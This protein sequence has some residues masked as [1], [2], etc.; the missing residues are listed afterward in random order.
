MQWIPECCICSMSG[1]GSVCPLDDG[2]RSHTGHLRPCVCQEFLLKIWAITFGPGRL[3]HGRNSI[4]L[5]SSACQ[6]M[7]AP[8]I[9]GKP[10]SGVG[11]KIHKA[12]GHPLAFLFSK[13]YIEGFADLWSSFHSPFSSGVAFMPFNIETLFSSSATGVWSWF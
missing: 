8:C 7:H 2:W 4:L 6:S 10:S 11:V 1:R 5:M 12:C 13:L 9:L 3:S